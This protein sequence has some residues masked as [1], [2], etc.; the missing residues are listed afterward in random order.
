MSPSDVMV[1]VNPKARSCEMEPELKQSLEEDR[2]TISR[3][4]FHYGSTRTIR[5]SKLLELCLSFRQVLHWSCSSSS[6]CAYGKAARV[7]FSRL[8][9]FRH[10][11]LIIYSTYIY[12]YVCVCRCVF[13]DRLETDRLVHMHLDS[14][15]S[16]CTIWTRRGW[17]LPRASQPRA[18][19]KVTTTCSFSLSSR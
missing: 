9:F 8:R 15:M 19:R 1:H 12:V 5:G 14:Y 2:S 17:H 10:A 18:R 11:N 3:S 4:M 16:H 6:S 7:H 13:V